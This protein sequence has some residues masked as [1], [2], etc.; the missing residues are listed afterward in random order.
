MTQ[1]AIGGDVMPAKGTGLAVSKYQILGNSYLVVSPAENEA[2]AAL[3]ER[4]ADAGA[5]L[6]ARL[7]AALCSLDYGV[8]ASGVVFGPLPGGDGRM[9][10]HIYNED[11]SRCNFSGNATRMLALHLARTGA[12]DDVAGARLNLEVVGFDAEGRSRVAHARVEI[13]EPG[14]GALRIVLP[15][16]VIG[17]GSVRATPE[18]V[19]DGVRPDGAPQEVD[20]WLTV[21]AIAALGRRLERPRQWDSV[22]LLDVGNPHCVVFVRDGADLPNADFADVPRGDLVALSYA[23]TQGSSTFAETF[24]AG[25][26]L[27]FAHVEPETSRLVLRTFERGGGPTRSSG[28][29]SSA[30]AAAAYARGL[31]GREVRVAMPGGEIDIAL[32]GCSGAIGEMMLSSPVVP[33]ADATVSFAALGF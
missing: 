28:S 7:V 9:R 27:Q 20:V 12:L 6:P 30:A 29:S 19:L 17:R 23:G 11:G 2:L 8:G 13:V 14:G 31:V 5:A 16:P 26:N 25:C 33:V 4:G 3:L 18:A 22:A 10:L 15:A 21:P 32:D 24:P 1:I